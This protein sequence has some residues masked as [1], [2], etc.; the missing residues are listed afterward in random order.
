MITDGLQPGDRIAIMCSNRWEWVICDQAAQG[1]G[2]VTV[3]IYT[4][5][6]AGEY[7]LIPKTPA[8]VCC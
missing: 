3:P 8:P 1:L 2:L 5:D 4:N 6:R 7:R